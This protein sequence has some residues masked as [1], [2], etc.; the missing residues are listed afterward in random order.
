MLPFKTIQVDRVYRAERPQKGRLREFV[1][2]DIDILGSDSMN[3]ELELIDTTA[4]ALLAI[5]IGEFR[6]K[7]NDRRILK[8]ILSHMGF[9][10]KELDR[11]CI[12]F[13]K[14]DKIG[15][16]GVENELNMT[17]FSAEAIRSFV[18]FL[19]KGQFTLSSLRSLL[20][21]DNHNYID[22]IES[23]IQSA[24]ELAEGKYEVVFDVS[25]VR[26]QGYYT[27]TIFEVESTKFRGA[28]AGGG[29]Y[30]HLIG[31]FVNEDIPAVGFSIGFERIY[32]ILNENGFVAQE[33]RKRIALF[34]M[35]DQF[36]EA[37]KKAN[38]LRNEYDVTLYEK[39]KKLGKF[40]NR[41]EEQNINGF[42]VFGESDD[43][44]LMEA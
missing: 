18:E 40:L 2:C 11:V 16:E 24:N 9:A 44:K 35:P 32:S 41:L 14:M 42:I 38:E 29:R 37:T 20:P 33:S 10:D 43:I 27:G 25:L 17:G 5:Q 39:P 4:K 12:I 36:I 1:Q 22:Q 34:Y 28:I 19:S 23:L 13:D 26:G 21:I 3:C 15:C 30:D 31:K 6:V 8:A 7:V